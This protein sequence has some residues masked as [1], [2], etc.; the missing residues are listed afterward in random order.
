MSRHS[1]KP[2]SFLPFVANEL[3]TPSLVLG[4]L[5]AAIK[6]QADALKKR[7]TN[8]IS[9][10]LPT[11]LRKWDEL[12]YIN[13]DFGED[14]FEEEAARE[15][16]LR[17]DAVYNPYP[18][19]YRK[20]YQD[21]VSFIR[22]ARDCNLPEILP[23]LF[24]SLCRQTGESDRHLQKMDNSDLL[25]LSA[26]KTCLLQYI[27][28]N[29]L[30]NIGLRYK[31]SKIPVTNYE[32]KFCAEC[33]SPLRTIWLGILEENMG[34]ADPLETFRSYSFMLRR[35][36]HRR[37]RSE[38]ASP[39]TVS[40]ADCDLYLARSLGDLRQKLWKLLPSFFT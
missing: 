9:S 34:S 16:S 13:D 37:M 19:S 12:A 3:N 28:H 4:P 35:R 38:S 22:L 24:Y 8:H 15:N 26:G 2:F 1:L 36:A 14:D 30:Q 20:V 29:A 31:N 23:P 10:C 17:E 11:T 5:K 25:V 32:E 21:P 18:L 39:G 7:I 33:F 27:S 40:C 6:Y